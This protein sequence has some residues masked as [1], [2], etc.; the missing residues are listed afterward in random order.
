MSEK[1]F[2]NNPMVVMNADLVTNINFSE[3]LEFHNKSVLLG[4]L[5]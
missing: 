1:D 4:H 5:M 3:L 2:D